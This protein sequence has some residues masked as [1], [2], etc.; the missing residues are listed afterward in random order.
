MNQPGST[1]C[2]NCGRL[3]SLN[4]TNC[5]NCGFPIRKNRFFQQLFGPGFDIIQGIVYFCSGIYII[6][7]LFDPSAIFQMGGL[8]RILSPSSKAI[9]LLG[10]TGT[11]SVFQLGYF[12]TPLTAIFLHGG[13]LHILFNMLWTRQIGYI[14]KDLYGI[15]RFILIF[16]ISGVIGFIASILAGHQLTLGAS[17]SIFGLLG[18]LVYY[19]R[20]RG[21]FFGQNI[22][23]QTGIWAIVLFAFGLIMPGVD[24]FAHGG[25]FIG[26]YLTAMLVSFTE[27]YHE[28]TWHQYLGL[29]LI[30][31]TVLAFGFHIISFLYFKLAYAF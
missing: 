9:I 25:G 8:F 18:A 6:S 3:V 12:W 27:N 10:G 14:V 20:T 28:K 30:I 29:G 7:L 4:S 13:I 15:Y 16:I 23:K 21:G 11:Y 31:I 24:N 17:G 22:Y 5:F 1:V 26:G 2:P 19:G